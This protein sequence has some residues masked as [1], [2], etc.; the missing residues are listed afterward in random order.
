[1]EEPQN[2]HYN[3]STL[4]IIFAIS[5]VILLG[6]VLWM[7]WDDYTRDWKQHQN[8]FRTFEIE[9]SRVK[10]D[11][12]LTALDKQKEYQALLIELEVAKKKFDANCNFKGLESELTGIKAENALSRQNYKFSKAELDAAKYRYEAAL[13]H[14]G[15]NLADVKQEFFDLDKEV[16][17]LKLAV[18][19][20]NTKLEEKSAVIDLC[21]QE[22][23]NLQKRQRQLAGQAKVLE[24]KLA[25]IDP[26]KMSFANRIGDLARDLPVLDLANPKVKIEQ[27]VLN[28]LTDDVKFMR[29]PKVERCITCHLGIANPDYVNA[30][31]PYTTHPDLELFVANNSPHALEEFGC[32]VCHGG[33]GRGTDFV[34]SVHTPSSNEQKKQWEEKYSWEKFHH[35]EDPMF[36]LPYTEAGCFKCHSGVKGAEKLNLGLNIIEKAGCYNC[37]VIEK[38]KEWPK[39]GPNLKKIASKVSRDWAFKWINDPQ[40]FRHNTWMPAFFDQSNNNDSESKARTEQEIHAIV[41][42][43]F[44]KS[45]TYSMA[46]IPFKGSAAKGEELVASVGCLACHEIDEHPSDVDTTRENLREEFGPYL[47]GIGSKTSKQWLFNWL[48]NPNSYHAQTRMPN[49]RLSNQEAADISEYLVVNLNSEF[50]NQVVPPKDEGIIDKMVLDFLKRSETSRAAQE[51][52]NSMSM[53]EKLTL[54]GEKLIAHYGCY[55]CHN[56]DGFEQLK[57]VG[58]ELTEEGNKAIDKL[59]FGFIHIEHSLQGWFKQKLLEPRIFDKEKVKTWDEKLKMPNFHFTDQEADAI[60][61][62]LLGFVN[63]ESVTN[64]IKPRTP[65]NI[66]IEEGQEIIRQFNCQ[67]CHIIEGEGG[68]IKGKVEQWLVKYNDKTVDE[69]SAASTSFSPPN[70]IGEGKKVQSQWLFEFLHQ[71]TT[72]R[73]W[74]KIKMPTFDFNASHLNA[75]VKYFNALD[76]EEFPYSEPIDTTLTEDELIAAENLFSSEYFDCAKCHIVGDKLPGG[77]ADNWAPNFALARTRLKPQWIIEWL[78]NPADLLP[79]TK[80]PTYFDPEAFDVSGPDDILNGDEHEQIRVLRNYLLTLADSSSEAKKKASA[81]PA[82]TEPKPQAEPAESL[83]DQTQAPAE[84]TPPS[85]E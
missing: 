37:H 68:T 84:E 70:L 44:A 26:D 10:Y 60:V 18:E 58:T 80:M 6:A 55:S 19:N 23:D 14:H 4:N 31:Q 78:M 16:N 29:V 41:H 2:R 43:L 17:D 66:M 74:L 13:A 63:Q 11:D 9:K 42:T 61:T 53:N 56:I 54:S 25:K 33:R 32:T 57:P 85:A 22:L 52:L 50:D 15:K 75:L 21:G 82:I 81:P 51:K 59:D 65:Q 72:I 34:S 5:S 12:T 35:W 45:E 8:D 48:K 62:A 79:G 36:P 20:S 69:A 1:V 3:I 30:P 67:G 40:S 7:T 28:D 64:K 39:S 24:L 38:Y 27:V 49:L 83:D 71:P 47:T 76:N 73:P 46:E 77:T